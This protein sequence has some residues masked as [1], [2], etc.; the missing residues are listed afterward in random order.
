M[1]TRAKYLEIQVKKL[2]YDGFTRTGS[3]RTP[4]VRFAKTFKSRLRAGRLFEVVI[5][6]PINSDANVPVHMK[7]GEVVM[8]LGFDESTHK[9]NIGKTITVDV[10]KMLYKDTVWS[11]EPR[12]VMHRNFF[13]YFVRANK[14]IPV[15][16][17]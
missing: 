9:N 12:S 3:K 14:N 7:Q 2:E 4:N 5:P 6:F 17:Q 1:M 15:G 16:A 10:L 13:S 11:F 8:S